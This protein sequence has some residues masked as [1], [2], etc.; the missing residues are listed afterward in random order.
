VKILF[1]I[2][3]TNRY[4][5]WA[6]GGLWTL[7]TIICL[8]VGVQVAKDYHVKGTKKDVY[9]ISK[10][11]TQEVLYLDVN[12]NFKDIESQSSKIENWMIYMDDEQSQL[13]ALPELDIE[14]SDNDSIELEVRLYARGP[15]RKDAI[16][17]AD[18]INYIYSLTDSVINFDKYMYLEQGDK[19]RFQD[20]KMILHLPVGQTIFLSKEMKS[21]I[22]DIDNV[23][24]TWDSDMVNRRWKMTQNGLACVDCDN[25][26]NIDSEDE[27]EDW[28]TEA[29]EL[30]GPPPP[31]ELPVPSATERKTHHKTE[32]V[33]SE[34]G[35]TREQYEMLSKLNRMYL[36]LKYPDTNLVL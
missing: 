26:K 30:P 36:E 19:W 12:N 24:N 22:F 11:R 20:V 35:V 6:S 34:S 4:V 17:R 32:A 33:L 9:T 10:P 1:N 28:D 29:P 8:I 14:K 23:T 13:F 18:R 21:I 3:G 7:G 16:S 27:S 31:P 5:G 25:L 2:K 15:S